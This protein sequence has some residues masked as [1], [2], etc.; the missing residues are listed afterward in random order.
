MNL[1]DI[2]TNTWLIPEPD[3]SSKKSWSYPTD[4]QQPNK[5]QYSRNY[6]NQ[7]ATCV[8]CGQITRDWWYHNGAKKICKCNACKKNGHV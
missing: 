6:S 1:Y 4:K 8:F 5:Q 2:S 3:N 7:E